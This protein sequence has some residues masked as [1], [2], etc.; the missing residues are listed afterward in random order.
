M[1]TLEKSILINK[2]PN[3]KSRMFETV[4]SYPVVLTIVYD[5][6]YKYGKVGTLTIINE[7]NQ[8]RVVL[9]A[10]TVANVLQG[11]D[12]EIYEPNNLMVL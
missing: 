11:I 12:F 5:V 9:P 7:S 2:K 4:E 8:K 3:S 10:T 1:L 6:R